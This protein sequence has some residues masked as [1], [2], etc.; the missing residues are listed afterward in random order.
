[1]NDLFS[2]NG[3]SVTDFLDATVYFLGAMLGFFIL[4]HKKRNWLKN[5]LLIM[6]VVYW[7]MTLA[8]PK[9]VEVKVLATL[10]MLSIVV[11]R[12]LVARREKIVS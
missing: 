6:F 3:I 2:S 1:M 4:R 5:A 10:F 9:P 11:I 7:I 12:F 8:S